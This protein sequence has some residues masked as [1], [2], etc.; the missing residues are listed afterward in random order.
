MRRSIV[1]VVLG[2]AV[3]TF[4]CASSAHAQPS[5]E[6]KKL[7]FFVGKWKVDTDV[8]ASDDGPANKTS[9]IEECEWFAN[10]HVVCKADS[11]TAAGNYR[12]MRILSWVPALKVYA[13]YA[14]D[15]YG[16]AL[17][18]TGQLSGNTWTFTTDLPGGKMRTTIKTAGDGYT[19]TSGLVGAGGK[20]TQTG[21]GKGARTK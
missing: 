18:S 14:V 7:E 2:I 5:P 11:T 12:T 16:Y 6:Q 9:G 20:F 21:T 3:S 4:V 8:K 19:V 10:L 1:S 15:S 13:Q 17:L